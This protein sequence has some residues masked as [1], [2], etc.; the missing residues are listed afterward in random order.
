M[1][2]L[3]YM[4]N[5]A[6]TRMDNRVREAMMPYFSKKYSNPSGIYDFAKENRRA[7]EE[8]KEKIA[9]LINAEP[10]EIYFTSGGTEAD[11][12][13]INGIFEQT[14][15]R[16]MITSSIEHHAI[17]RTCEHLEHE[18]YKID[19]IIPDEWG[20]ITPDRIQKC[21]GKDTALVSVMTANNEIG[22]IQ[23][24]EEI[25]NICHKNN[26]IFHTDAVQAYGHIPI[27]VNK[28]NIDLMSVSGHKFGGPKG[29]GFLYVS[30]NI[31]IE[32]YMRGGSQEKGK[33][34]GT[35]NVPGIVGLGE[36]ALIA[37]NAMDER[38]RYETELRDR[39]IS[40]ILRNVPYTRLNGHYSRR[41]PGNANFGFQFIDGETLL[42]ML[43]EKGICASTGSACSAESANPSHVLMAIG[44]PEEIA[45]GSVRFS[46]SYE[47]TY[48][49][50]DYVC[51]IVKESVELLRKYS[52]KI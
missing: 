26:I 11:N 43:D 31:D 30:K 25:G 47:N 35:Y 4:D 24:V 2:N 34:A 36:A 8:S 52:N 37:G 39:M 18:N 3:I 10:E 51:R 13:A 49:E 28:M 38:I 20:Q 41:L 12:W 15:K 5:A 27:D 21:I 42:V 6:T 1:E 48:E 44:L 19:Y 7:I 22:T 9:K 17:L 46:L 14:D 29:I 23:P 50:V 40:N 45:Y 32:P 16:H 33:R